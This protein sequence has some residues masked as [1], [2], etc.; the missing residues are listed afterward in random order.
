MRLAVLRLATLAA[1][2]SVAAGGG[3]STARAQ[4]VATVKTGIA[5]GAALSQGWN[6]PGLTLLGSA[7]VGR[8]G[9]RLGLR[10]ELLYSRF[11]DQGRGLLGVV[12]PGC[13]IVPPFGE[14]RSIE[15]SFGALVGATYALTPHAARLRPYLL[16]G[17]GI[18]RSLAALSGTPDASCTPPA[19]CT[20]SAA[21]LDRSREIRRGTNAGLHAGLGAA[22]SAGSLDLTAE[23]RFHAL[24]RD[25][26]SGRFFPLTV[27]VRF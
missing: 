12:C 24:E 20:M 14:W 4:S 13:D 5:A 2:T 25:A 19:V 22:F 26:G 3:S 6:G 1:I 23:A 27:G 7:D 10:G 8:L 11:S 15:Q 17:V 9:T 16:G 21:S 18:Y